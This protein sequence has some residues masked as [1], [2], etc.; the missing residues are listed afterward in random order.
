[1][2]RAWLIT[3]HQYPPSFLYVQ[4]LT[5]RPL[6]TVTSRCSVVCLKLT[7]PQTWHKRPSSCRSPDNLPDFILCHFPPP[8]VHAMPFLCSR[9]SVMSTLEVVVF[10]G[11][12]FIRK[13]NCIVCSGG[14][15]DNSS[16]KDSRALN[17]ADWLTFLVQLHRDC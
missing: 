4:L 17:P 6:Y 12:H 10:T 2:K 15:G 1:M 14:A 9:V 16:D 7:V 13:R 5:S 3:S 8:F 11:F